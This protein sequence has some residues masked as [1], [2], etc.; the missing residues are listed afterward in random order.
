MTELTPMSLFTAEGTAAVPGSPAIIGIRCNACDAVAFPFQPFGC[1]NCGSADV[2]QSR[3]DG[4]GQVLTTA[5]VHFHADPARPAPFT[6]AAVLL[7]CGAFVRGVVAEESAGD[8]EI[9]DTVET[10]LVPEVRAGR[11]D[12]DIRFLKKVAG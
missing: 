5:V 9:G 3:F 10:Q 7:D 6:I 1:E 12:T 4:R 11:G 2:E 8:I